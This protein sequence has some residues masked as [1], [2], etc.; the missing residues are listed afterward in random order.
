[1]FP[2]S[3]MT[4]DFS[5]H[6]ALAFK[7][8]RDGRI[9]LEGA[10][11][12]MRAASLIKLPILLCA[13]TEVARANLSLDQRLEL[14]ADELAGGAGLLQALQPGLTP[15]VLDLLTLMIIVSDN[16]ATNMMIDMLGID[17]INSY[18]QSL[19]MSQT[20]LVGKLQLPES[21]RN[22]AQRSGEVNR[23]CAADVLGLL[24]QL[25]ERDLLS[26]ELTLLALD[27]L[28][29]QQFTEALAR[30]L[31]TDAELDPDYVQV[32]SKSGSLRG[33]WHDA[34]IVYDREGTALYALVIM[35][36]GAADQS[37]SWEQEGMMLIAR[38]SKTIFDTVRNAI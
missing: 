5:G 32:A 10:T 33:L 8:L 35:T 28:K 30:Y 38:V 24:V 19:G 12:T 34:G 36:D 27:I 11:Q 23:T 18:I 7:D 22:A 20:K 15:T 21:Q 14:K 17:K 29:K 13:F 3:L 9:Q 26:D 4:R 25:E 2:V 6:Y 31:P 16:T 37:Y 1:M